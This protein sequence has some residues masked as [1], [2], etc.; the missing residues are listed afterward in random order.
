MS[1]QSTI[2]FVPELRADAISYGIPVLVGM[3]R[4]EYDGGDGPP[5]AGATI[6]SVIT[7]I[8]LSVMA[9][10]QAT[11]RNPPPLILPVKPPHARERS[12]PPPF[13]R[14]D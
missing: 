4:G 9:L 7:L 2:I 13:S 8:E 10:A 5:G 6:D 12:R 14:N 1:L 11:E 3:L